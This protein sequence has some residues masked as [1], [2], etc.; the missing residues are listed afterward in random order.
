MR[1]RRFLG[2]L[3][4]AALPAAAAAEPPSDAAVL[5]AFARIAFGDELVPDP[6]P[7]L[8]KWARPIRWRSFESLS[9]EDGERAFLERHIERLARLTG[10]D[11]APATSWPEANLVILFVAE[12]RY[13]ATLARY[14]APQRRDLLP[15][16]AATAC[17]GLVQH[18]RVTFEIEFAVAIVP[19]DR[20]RARGLATSCIAEE[21]TQVL[22]LPNDV[23]LEGTLFNDK[24]KARDLTPLDE[25]LVRLLYD[26][27]L[28]SGMRRGEALAAAREILPELRAARR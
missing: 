19:L 11:L 9:L 7:R 16:L 15:K 5:D 26:R 8:Q 2:V 20:A 6:D 10:H 23:D 4:L 17:A 25:M 14:L 22:G 27:R 18:H 12:E 21:T 1:L 13:E 28:K 24:G 3:I